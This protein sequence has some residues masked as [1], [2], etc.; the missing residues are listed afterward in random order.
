MTTQP[1]NFDLSCGIEDPPPNARILNATD[2][3]RYH[4]RISPGPKSESAG[5]WYRY[6]GVNQTEILPKWHVSDQN[7][8]FFGAEQTLFAID[9]RSGDLLNTVGGLTFVQSIERTRQG[10]ILA[11]CETD[12]VLFNGDGSLRWRTSIPDVIQNIVE[13]TSSFQVEG[14]EG[15]R[16][17]FSSATGSHLRTF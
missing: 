6:I 2:Q 16:F 14:I 17:E 3:P 15:S 1:T 12:L 10:S 11:A 5:V 4:W 9:A 13:T 8:I 7:V